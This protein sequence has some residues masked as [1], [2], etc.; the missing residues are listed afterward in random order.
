MKKK[1]FE[2]TLTFIIAIK[3][4]TQINQKINKFFAFLIRK[5]Y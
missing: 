3:T 5:N 4:I 2:K 1:T